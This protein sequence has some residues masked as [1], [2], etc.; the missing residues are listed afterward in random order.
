MAPAHAQQ[1][2]TQ[3][4]L[5][6]TDIPFELDRGRNVSV[7]SRP[8]PELEP[9]GVPVGGLRLY[10]SLTVGA[11]Y[12]SNVYGATDNGV[13]DVAALIA[14]KVELRSDWGRHFFKVEASGDFRRFASETLRNQDGYDVDAQGS[15]NVVGDST[16]YGYAGIQRTYEAQYSGAFPANSAS[17]VPVTRKM[18]IARG[19]Y[20]QNRIRLTLNL[21]YTN[22]DYKDNEALSGE[23]ID[24][25]FRD[26]D[27]ARV[28]G[29]AEYAI[30]PDTAVFVQA[31][32]AKSNYDSPMVA[33]PQ[34][35]N[36]EVRLLAGLAFDLTSL[37]RAGIG[38]G[39][40]SRDYDSS[41]YPRMTNVAVDAR[42]EYFLTQLTTITVLGRRAIEDSIVGASPGFVA[43]TI[44]GRVDHEL[45][46]N[47]I[48]YAGADY[49]DD[50]FAAITRK[51]SQ[52]RLTG[53]ALYT[54]YRNLVIEPNVTYVDRKSRGELAG[55]SFNELRFVLKTT[56]RR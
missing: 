2:P 25:D 40:V 7:M 22:L 44:S 38:V 14:P 16:I 13:S 8:K 42:L 33:Q 29:R 47:L 28:S 36:S 3:S 45:L 53:G 50:N 12:S 6:A 17:P 23:R 21:D 9:Q 49:E 19:T 48:L 43:T 20:V 31:S 24:E 46:R 52:Y 18:A 56:I 30:T 1:S 41:F 35:D 51:D 37:I 55:Q 54:A 5:L 4:P 39:Y 11:D 10:P 15:V 26:R 27:V 32:Y 34:R